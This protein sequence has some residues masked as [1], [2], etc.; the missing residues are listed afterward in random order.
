MLASEFLTLIGIGLLQP[1]FQTL[2]CLVAPSDVDLRVFLKSL[3][4]TCIG[5][6]LKSG[7]LLRFQF[8]TSFV[9]LLNQG[10]KF[11]WLKCKSKRRSKEEFNKLYTNFSKENLMIVECIE[12]MLTKL[13][14]YIY[15]IHRVPSLH[16]D[17]PELLSLGNYEILACEPLHDR[18]DRHTGIQTYRHTRIYTL[19]LLLSI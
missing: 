16:F 10:C 15:G 14:T 4:F 8:S 12:S 9:N 6:F 1:I 18:H 3:L 7:A 5:K 13:T 2:H 11:G 19:L 17:F